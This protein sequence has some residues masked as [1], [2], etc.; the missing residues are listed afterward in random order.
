MSTFL[1]DA[2]LWGLILWVVGY[3]LGIVC[4]ALVPVTMIGWVLLPVALAITIWV[5][6]KKVNGPS[7]IYYLGVG[8]AWTLIAVVLDYLMIVKLFHPPDGYYK[9]DVYIYYALMFLLPLI[10][11]LVKRPGRA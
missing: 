8:I 4:F 7:L 3:A 9:L 2:F 1:K 6:S 5:L 10:A 11:G